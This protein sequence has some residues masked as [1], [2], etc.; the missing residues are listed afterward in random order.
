MTK[1]S[2][3]IEK[4]H[5]RIP[6]DNYVTP[7]EIAWWTVE[8]CIYI[9][10]RYSGSKPNNELRMLE[11]GCGDYRPFMLS[12]ITRGIKAYGIDARDVAPSPKALII[13]GKSF[14]DMPDE[15]NAPIYAQKY[16]IIAT[17]PPFIYAEEFIIRSL[18]LLAPRGVA[19]FLTKMSFLGTQGRRPFFDERPPS[20]VHILTKRPSFA[21]GG[22]DRGQE[23]AVLFWNGSEVDKKI[24]S[25]YGRISRLY[26]EENAAWY[27]TAVGTIEGKGKRVVVNK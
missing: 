3:L 5:D 27:A 14:L 22:T 24:R 16:D 2:K 15:N 18:D 12:A 7:F 26:W 10:D 13:S 9:S 25:K 19:A 21:H 17:N 4:K 6:S 8:H 20:E 23:Y 1:E 11:P